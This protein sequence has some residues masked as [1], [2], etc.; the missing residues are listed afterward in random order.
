MQF[1]EYIVLCNTRREY[2]E[3]KLEE[4]RRAME[5]R[6]LNIGRRTI[7]LGCNEHQAT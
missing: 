6:V 2:V 5:E 4:W 1:A 7:N 3:K